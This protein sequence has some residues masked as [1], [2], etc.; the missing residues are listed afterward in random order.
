METSKRSKRNV[1]NFARHNKGFKECL[2]TH[3]I[4]RFRDLIDKVDT[5]EEET[6]LPECMYFGAIEKLKDVQEDLRKLDDI[7]HVRRII[8]PFLINWG[9]MG[10]VVGRKD[11]D[12]RKLGETLRSLEPAFAKLRNKRL[13]NIK[14]DE[15]I[16]SNA[17]K[18]IYHKLRIIPYIGSP[19]ALSKILHL[20]N[21]EVFV[22]WD[23]DI[24]KKYKEKNK[25][26]GDSPDGYLEFLKEVQKELKEA[27]EDRQRE[28]GRSLDEIEQEIRNRY[29]NKTLARIVDEYNWITAHP[30]FI[31]LN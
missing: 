22:M 15:A 18:E 26:V 3:I 19:T 20:L 14:L 16:F 29:K 17:I 2:A 12:W 4:M 9:M 8:K 31:D 24:R 10:R 30:N 6:E 21:P 13:I 25:R 28:T 27:L 5:F 23:S 11:L 7:L 1:K